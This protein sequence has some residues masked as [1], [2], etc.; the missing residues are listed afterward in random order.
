MPKILHL[1]KYFCY[2]V[3]QVPVGKYYIYLTYNA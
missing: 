2:K 1:G 3:V